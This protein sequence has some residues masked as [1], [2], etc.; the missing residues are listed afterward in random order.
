[1]ARHVLKS[2]L[3]MW[4]KMN[5]RLGIINLCMSVDYHCV[6]ATLLFSM[7]AS[8]VKQLT[9]KVAIKLIWFN[10]WGVLQGYTQIGDKLMEH[11]ST[12]YVCANKST[13][14]QWWAF[15]WNYLDSLW[16]HFYIMIFLMVHVPLKSM[17]IMP[18]VCFG[19][20]SPV[21]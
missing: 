11:P 15:S 18:N 10:W 4:R 6:H 9:L 7:H 5:F 8:E 13:G 20:Y 19:F 14:I 1:M 12:R 16:I 17:T 3:S 21:I 2:R